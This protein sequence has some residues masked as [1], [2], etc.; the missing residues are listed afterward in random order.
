M[1]RTAQTPKPVEDVVSMDVYGQTHQVVVSPT[2]T[3]WIARSAVHL[4]SAEGASRHHALSNLHLA[5]RYLLHLKAR[6]SA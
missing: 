2:A 6:I 1:L 4:L 5:V 3:G